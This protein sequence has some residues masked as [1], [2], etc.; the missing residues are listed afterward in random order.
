MTTSNLQIVIKSRPT[1]AMIPSETFTSRIVPPAT[2]ADLEDGQVLVETLYLSLDP[3]MRG[4]LNAGNGIVDTAVGEPMPGF[5]LARVLTSRSPDLNPGDIVTAFSVWARTAVLPAG[6]VE[7]VTY[8]PA[9]LPLTD[10]LGVLG[11][12]G[13][14]AY[15]GMLG[16]G[17]P[18]PGEMVVVSSAA[19]ATG[20]VAAQLA[21]IRGARVVA[22]AGG[23]QKGK[24]LRELGIDEVLDYKD[25]AFEEQFRKAM[26]GGIDLYF[27][28]VGGRILELAIANMK[29]F[30]RIILNG[31]MSGYNTTTPHGIK[32]LFP[33]APKSATIHGLN[34]FHHLK[35]AA[36]ARA[37]LSQWLQ[38]GTL[39]RTQTVVEG[40]LDAAPQGLADLF[41]GKNTGKMLV[42]VKGG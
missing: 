27:D 3:I 30:G 26:K 41:K 20:S 32:S 1:G 35:F 33:I 15:F 13:L 34:I 23:E 40:G 19:G 37:E 31:D 18:K 38:D 42:E 10:V 21:K 36:T 16:I 24:W 29:A 12:T 11:L 39:Q 8:L 25:D 17:K 14:T 28:S 9:G 22:I 4:W 6:S 7:K 5:I 2:E